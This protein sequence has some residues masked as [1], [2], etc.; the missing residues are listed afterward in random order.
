MQERGLLTKAN[1]DALFEAGKRIDASARENVDKEGKWHVLLYMDNPAEDRASIWVGPRHIRIYAGKRTPIYNML[2][3]EPGYKY[4]HRERRITFYSIEEALDFINSNLCQDSSALPDSINTPAMP[5]GMSAD[6]F[7][8]ICPRCDT[9]F[10]KADRCPE[11]GQLI[12][13]PEG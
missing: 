3:E 2:P 9:K 5:K 7:V 13:Y 6:G 12:K 4:K 1:Q 11:C 8:V 10:K